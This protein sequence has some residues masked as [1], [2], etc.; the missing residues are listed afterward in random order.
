MF[1]C[2]M[3]T[4]LAPQPTGTLLQV[5]MKGIKEYNVSYEFLS[6]LAGYIVLGGATTIYRRQSLYR[7]IIQHHHK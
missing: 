5:N 1:D 2:S 7:Q 6:W 3:Q 4:K